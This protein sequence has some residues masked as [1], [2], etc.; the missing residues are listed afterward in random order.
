MNAFDHICVTARRVIRK[1]GVNT[2]IIYEVFYV[3]KKLE[4][5]YHSRQV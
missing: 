5:N 1:V 4:Q 3:Y 2:T